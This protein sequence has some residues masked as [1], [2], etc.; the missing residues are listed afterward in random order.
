MPVSEEIKSEND[1]IKNRNNLNNAQAHGV[2]EIKSVVDELLY[3]LKAIY[4]QN[5][6]WM[7]LKHRLESEYPDF[8]SKI[9]IAYIY[10]YSRYLEQK[11]FRNEDLLKNP[12]LVI[13]N[14]NTL[15][16][17]ELVSDEYS[18]FSYL[19]GQSTNTIANSPFEG[20]ELAA[21]LLAATIKAKSKLLKTDGLQASVQKMSIDDFYKAVGDLKEKPNNTLNF[22]K[23]SIT[24]D[25][26]NKV[27]LGMLILSFED[28]VN[29]KGVFQVD[30]E[31][32]TTK[33]GKTFAAIPDINE[34]KKYRGV[35]E[36]YNGK[37]VTDEIRSDFLTDVYNLQKKEPEKKKEEATNSDT[38]IE[39]KLALNIANYITGRISASEFQERD[40]EI[41]SENGL[42]NLDEE[43]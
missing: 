25:S 36:K 43:N 27:F 23:N 7:K 28:L 18:F 40:Q 41:K 19:L 24:T 16:N 2:Q 14:L 6:P 32:T 9:Q 33:L 17:G 8:L 30:L 20:T 38:G 22:I 5:E 21:N 3:F 31:D 39:D 4:S 29:R 26:V 35:V 1:P 37:T 13:K 34:R 15:N 12:D 11:L 10:Y 42:Q